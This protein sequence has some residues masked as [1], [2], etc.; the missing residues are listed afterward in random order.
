MASAESICSMGHCKPITRFIKLRNIKGKKKF[1]NMGLIYGKAGALIDM[2]SWIIEKGFT[3][4]QLGICLYFEKNYTDMSLTIDSESEYLFNSER[5]MH[6]NN[7]SAFF[8][9]F[10]GMYCFNRY[11]LNFAYA[12]VGYKTNSHYILDND[13]NYNCNIIILF[14]ISI[15]ESNIYDI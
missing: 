15:K 5:N 7:T 3:D 9:H 12:L 14:Y 1:V 11:A 13:R 8:V 6:D 10:P 4:D 2:Y